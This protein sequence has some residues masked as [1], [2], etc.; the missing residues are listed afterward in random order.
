MGYRLWGTIF[1]ILLGV[2]VVTGGSVRAE[3]VGRPDPAVEEW[4]DWPF[5]AACY[6]PPFDPVSVFSGPTGAERGTRPPEVALRRV[7]HDPQFS[8]LRFPLH[9]WRSV[10]ESDSQAVFANG[11]LSDGYLL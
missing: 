11:R 5:R 10:A 8:W 9:R 4:P 3:T 1:A 7:L 6:A 2:L